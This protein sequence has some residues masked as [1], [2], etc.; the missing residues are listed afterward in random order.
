MVLHTEIRSGKWYYL[1]VQD[2]ARILLRG[3]LSIIPYSHQHWYDAFHLSI[4]ITSLALKRLLGPC[5][6]ICTLKDY[7]KIGA[8]VLPLHGLPN[9]LL[10][11]KR[12]SDVASN[13]LYL[14]I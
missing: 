5:T 1:T 12:K 14:I 9:T 8:S 6:I 2:N 7:G 13:D 11:S 3:A 4:R 10:Y